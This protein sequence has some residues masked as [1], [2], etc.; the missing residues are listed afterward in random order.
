MQLGVGRKFTIIGPQRTL[1]QW[2]YN[3]VQ[4]T[5]FQRDGAGS[6]S[7]RGVFDAIL[8]KNGDELTWVYDDTLQGAGGD[9]DTDIILIAMPEVEV[10]KRMSSVDTNVFA[11]LS[12]NNPTCL[13]Q[14]SDMAAP[15]EIISPL[16][17]GATDV[18]SE[19]RLTPGWAPRP[20]ALTIVTARYQ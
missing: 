16:A 6:E 4:L 14:Y 8:M 15:R 19:W 3:I 13:T 9:A 20:Q 2:E 7:T 11:T 1:S 12:P 17:G 18:L 10:P 5:S